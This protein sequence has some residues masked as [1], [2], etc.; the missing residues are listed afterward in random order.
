MLANTAKS[1][2]FDAVR[3]RLRAGRQHR[4]TQLHGRR[5]PAVAGASP[6]TITVRTPRVLSSEIRETR[7]LTGRV[8]ERY[9]PN[10]LQ[11]CWRARSYCQN[12][13]ALLFK[14]VS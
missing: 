9:Q 13:E 7:V 8:A 4:P 12:P 2:G 14:F 1:S 6:V 11:R 10:K 5:L 3:K